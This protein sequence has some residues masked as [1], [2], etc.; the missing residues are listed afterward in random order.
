M[1]LNDLLLSSILVAFGF[2]AGCV[3]GVIAAKRDDELSVTIVPTALWATVMPLVFLFIWSAGDAIFA[4]E[5]SLGHALLAGVGAVFLLGLWVP[6][7]TVVPAVISTIISYL[8]TRKCCPNRID[9]GHPTG[10]P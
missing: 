10:S 1:S 9:E 4:H 7:M 2:L 3:G 8:L 5:Y 6:I